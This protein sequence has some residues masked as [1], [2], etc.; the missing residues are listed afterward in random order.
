VG[1]GH[2]GVGAEEVSDDSRMRI[3]NSPIPLQNNRI[4]LIK[5]VKKRFQQKIFVN[6]RPE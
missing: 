4:R 6:N 5:L 2:V 3:I 1:G